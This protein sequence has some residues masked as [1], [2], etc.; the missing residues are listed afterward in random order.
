M[1]YAYSLVREIYRVSSAGQYSDLYIG[2][3]VC[4]H[5]KLHI[6]VEKTMRM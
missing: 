2:G 6:R 5:K 4:R 3:T 1:R